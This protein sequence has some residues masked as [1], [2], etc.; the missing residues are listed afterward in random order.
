M[1]TNNLAAAAQKAVG[2]G[3]RLSSQR[4]S[5]FAN[6]APMSR[7]VGAPMRSATSRKPVR[8][9]AMAP[10]RKAAPKKDVPMTPS[11]I[12]ARDGAGP[13]PLDSG[14]AGWDA[15]ELYDL[16]GLTWSFTSPSSTEGRNIVKAACKR[17]G[18]ALKGYSD[19]RKEDW[20]KMAAKA[21]VKFLDTFSTVAGMRGFRVC[22]AQHGVALMYV[23][24]IRRFYTLADIAAGVA[25]EKAERDAPEVVKVMENVGRVKKEFA[26]QFAIASDPALAAQAAVKANAPPAPPGSGDASP[27]AVGGADT[28]VQNN[29]AYPNPKSCVAKWYVFFYSRTGNQSLTSCFFV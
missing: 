29:Y 15:V 26:E 14:G 22:W 27:G 8:T 28:A 6:G 5:P 25:D 18:M 7:S 2:V 3:N 16:T 9:V 10:P 19:W 12:S 24:G 1:T 21:G 17:G 11:H 23:P 20:A 4:R 13:H